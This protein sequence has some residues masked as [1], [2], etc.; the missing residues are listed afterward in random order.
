M[1][2]SGGSAGLFGQAIEGSSGV[3][4]RNDF[5]AV[6]I[7]HAIQVVTGDQLVLTT[8]QLKSSSRLGLD[9][10]HKTALIERWLARG[11]AQLAQANQVPAFDPIPDQLGQV[12][13]VATAPKWAGQANSNS[14][15]QQ[16][17][18]EP[19]G[20]ALKIPQGDRSIHCL[21]GALA[22]QA[23]RIERIDQGD[24]LAGI[25]SGGMLC[26]GKMGAIGFHGGARA[27]VKGTQAL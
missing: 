16:L 6:P 13:A 20:L 17:Q 24:A 8:A 15:I 7:G 22:A 21:E 14:E 19:R 10:G 5:V 2:E 12:A 27:E 23:K 1:A 4:A 3:L 18:A 26:E 9:L 11:C 25:L